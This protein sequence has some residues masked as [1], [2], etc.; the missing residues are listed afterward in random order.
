MQLLH[1]IATTLLAAA[2]ARAPYVQAP[3]PQ[4]DEAPLE[5][6]TFSL[7]DTRLVRA[8][9]ASAEEHRAARRWREA[10]A[11][12]QKILEDHAGDLLPGERPRNTIG[13]ASDQPVH[14]GAAQRVREQL[15]EL[16]LEARELY[17]QRYGR[18]AQVAFDTARASG[19]AEALIE[20]AR[21]WPLTPSA[22]ASW[23]TLGDLD[24]EAGRSAE[25]VHAWARAVAYTL[26]DPRATP[27]DPAAWIS[28]RERLGARGTIEAGVARRI[29]LALESAKNATRDS[30]LLARN[31]RFPGGDESAGPPPG[32]EN[33]AWPEAFR[34]PWHPLQSAP[35]GDGMFA[36]KAG[37]RL[38]VSTGL[39]LLA[40]SAFGGD[41]LWDSGEPKGW[42]KLDDKDREDRFRGVDEDAVLLAPAATADVAVAAL[43]VPY[44]RL[45]FEQ[46]QRIDITR[47]LPERRLHAFDARTG[48]L[49]WSHAPPAKWDGESGDLATRLGCAGPPVIAGERVIVP[50]VRMQGR[51]DL[52]VAAFD[53]RDGSLLWSTALISGQREL[54]MFGRPEHE[55]C[56]PP[57]RVEGDRVVVL[58][59]L[60]AIA[61]V[62]LFS[63]EILWETL[64]NQIALPPTQEFR[65][66]TRMT[67]WR[68]CPP[69]V[70]DG[71]VVA[72]P[73][74]SE[75]AIGLDLATGALAWEWRNNQIHALAKS[76]IGMIDQLLGAS[77]R[78]VYLGG[79]R[80][81]ALEFGG[82]L[83]AAERPRVRWTWPEDDE[84]R[85][86][87]G[88][89][90]LFGDR[91]VVPFDTER[92]EIGTE[93]GR[94]LE[95]IAWPGGGGG[96]N[97]LSVPGELYTT[98]PLQV[99]GIFEW[100][101]LLARAREELA[102]RPRDVDSALAL[103]RL[104]AGRASADWARGQGEPARARYAEARSVL[105][106]ALAGGE[107]VV[108][109][110]L[111]RE[112]V[113]T[114]RGE[115]R[116]RS[117]LADSAGALELLRRARELA[118]DSTAARDVLLDRIAILRARGGTE[119]ETMI[120]SLADLE[121]SSG[122]E[123]MR[124]EVAEQ[125]DGAT[126]SLRVTFAPAGRMDGAEDGTFEI[127]CGLWVLCERALAHAAR[128]DSAAEFADLHAILERYG[129]IAIPTGTAG[130]LATERI[131]ALLASGTTAGYEPFEARARASL[132][133]ARTDKDGDALARV[134]L[135]HPGSLAAREANDALLTLA[136]ERADLAA[137]ARILAA[138]LPA[139]VAA[140]TL[141]DRTARL[142]LHLAGTALRAKN[143]ALA[144]ELLAMLSDARPEFVADV[145]GFDRLPLREL[146]ASQ[147]RFERWPGTTEVGRFRGDFRDRDV[148]PGDF[149]V[150]G[151]ALPDAALGELPVGAP[152]EMVVLQS[153]RDNE[154]RGAIV[155]LLASDDPTS[156]RWIAELPSSSLPRA[157]GP[158]MWSR[159]AAFAPGRLMLA[160]RGEILALDTATGGVAWR[161]APP[162][163][164]DGLAVGA[165]SGVAVVAISS[166]SDRPRLAAYDTAG[167]ALLWELSLQDG[168]VQR[169][170]LVSE[171]RVV[172]PP[173]SGQ[174][175][176]S[177]RDLFTGRLVS[178]FELPTPAVGGIDQ[179]AWTERG[180]VIVPWFDEMRLPE[181][182]HVVAFDLESGALAWRLPFDLSQKRMLSGVIQ[183]GERTWL[184]IGSLPRDEDPMPPPSLA[185]LA[186]GIGAST[187]LDMIRLGAEDV[188]IGLPRDT[189]VRLPEGP[190]FVLSPRGTRD[191]SPR[192]ARLRALDPTR[193]ELWVQGLGLSFDDLRSTGTPQAAWSDST[194]VVSLPMY[195]GNKRPPDLRTLVHVY[196]RD[197]GVFRETRKVERTDKADQPQLYAFGEVLLLRRPRNL[198][199]LR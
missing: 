22:A 37:D 167:G 99:R 20:V 182:N 166:R 194:V 199:I 130:E 62:D 104:L 195:D 92:V 106:A 8:V 177:V 68:N 91:V 46:F 12:F 98:S 122:D 188:V 165:A 108:D 191:G 110:A 174:T 184:R 18:D 50:L 52:H 34:L 93:D 161:A 190:L 25:A 136:L 64:Y 173:A 172:L 183:Q 23:W 111:A 197:T 6:H 17:V 58:T 169:A 145:P 176:G 72:V 63:G 120:A 3:I 13:H 162:G 124:V 5:T 196:D 117:Q 89:P 29:D 35:R 103:A 189:R 118:T 151:L 100:S 127:P 123:P 80:I 31:L 101:A 38:F 154:G 171:R 40:L 81:V 186:V 48:Q 90:A 28:A 87:V 187:P 19:E 121:A 16:P 96:G 86:R 78:T 33:D 44:I 175:R 139:E 94:V 129:A 26:G 79:D 43:Q 178:R 51:I 155:R 170:P 192:E 157:S 59:Q 85:Y 69:V 4:G 15:F 55:F 71:V 102:R 27:R 32:P 65:A 114:L 61:A 9:H 112:L 67:P 88:R 125:K 133:R 47:P 132:E 2:P 49:L 128:G 56:A 84:S 77:G 158:A 152:R 1:A 105:E 135:E 143:R 180:L 11:D 70:S 150:L 30:G 74:D 148:W 168:G 97:L 198:E 10:I 134:A 141:D 131:L 181:R 53:L 57:V 142:L 83:R 42:E 73:F 24:H 126:L 109:P 39:R 164:V 45:R 75:T 14:P 159:R 7:P 107:R 144:T 149:E 146:A 36:A 113:T 185:E 82:G 163:D 153:V 21:R 60:G 116:V 179:E 119:R 76:Q 137:V 115:A 66:P 95:R 140:T 147:P 193:G 41:L 156:P 160:L 54:N 138:E